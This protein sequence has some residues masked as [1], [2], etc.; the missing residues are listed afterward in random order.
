[1]SELNELLSGISEIADRKIIIIKPGT[2]CI[3][4]DN[5]PAPLTCEEVCEKDNLEDYSSYKMQIGKDN[6]RIFIE[7]ASDLNMSLDKLLLYNINNI[8]NRESSPIE[9]VIRL[10]DKA[11]AGEDISQLYQAYTIKGWFALVDGSS[12]P[13]E[14]SSIIEIINNTVDAIMVFEYGDNIIIVGDDCDKEA[15]CA[16]IYDNVLSE[17]YLECYIAVGGTIKAYSDIVDN[18]KNCREI[19]FLMKKYCLSSRVMDYDDVYAY[20]LAFG[21]DKKLKK[22]IKE[23]VFSHKLVE[24]MNSELEITIEAFF[25]NNLNLTDTAS[26]LY[27]H[28]NTLLYRI[29]KI[30]K[31][32]GFDLRKFEDSWLFKLAWII[33]KET[34]I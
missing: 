2:G 18:F 5:L 15:A 16:A 13:N 6:Y 19:L 3:Y 22:D 8:L 7:Q 9:Y 28:R 21:L 17:L 30:Y 27:I 29:D 33:N 34:T 12:S 10:L 32:T 25:K 14:K 23:R 1:M 31:A 20:R 26:K 24:I 4:P 11:E